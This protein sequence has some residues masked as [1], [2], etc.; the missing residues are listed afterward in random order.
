MQDG[1]IGEESASRAISLASLLSNSPLDSKEKRL[2]QVLE[3]LLK[4]CRGGVLFT[5]W[6]PTFDRLTS[7]S[8]NLQGKV[9]GLKMY[10]ASYS[11]SEARESEIARF[12]AH[13]DPSKWPLLVATRILQEGRDLQ[14]S[15]DCVIHY[16]LPSNPQAVEQRI[17]RVDRIGQ[18]SPT[19][20]VR[21]VLLRDFADHNFLLGMGQKI[22]DF[23]SNVGTMRP[24][25]PEGIC[26]TNNFGSVTDEMRE[27]IEKWNLDLIA[28]IDLAG[29]RDS[30]IPDGIVSKMPQEISDLSRDRIMQ[31]LEICLPPGSLSLPRGRIDI[32][33]PGANHL[34]MSPIVESS[35]YPE[36]VVSEL[37][38]CSNDERRAWEIPTNLE[39]LPIP[40][41]L[42]RS[43]LKISIHSVPGGESTLVIADESLQH[44][45]IEIHE[46]T[47]QHEGVKTTNW[48]PIR[49]IEG[50]AEVVG[51]SQIAR[52]LMNASENGSLEDASR[53]QSIPSGR[54]L[55]ELRENALKKSMIVWGRMR[56]MSDSRRAFSRA[57]WLEAQGVEQQKIDEI[58]E[59][60][61]ELR[62]EAEELENHLSLV[63]T[64][65]NRLTIL[66]DVNGIL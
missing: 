50:E 3:D 21:Y 24:I 42:R 43:L 8:L 58:R 6:Q 49:F 63:A 61:Q 10:V 11:D 28:D 15:A 38:R 45:A 59:S 19:V 56:L 44:Q 47:I 1:I 60:A 39:G 16:D 18:S 4:R 51:L 48:I 17:G 65:D 54:A 36:R 13:D 32:E 37:K 64:C 7:T 22:S 46:L 62:K 14:D 20:E 66:G 40:K 12:R 33:P 34:A 35:D 9:P 26:N 41:N 23:E 2:I 55:L 31:T 29:F 25:L 52:P 57:S 30:S 27:Q 53:Y 5:N